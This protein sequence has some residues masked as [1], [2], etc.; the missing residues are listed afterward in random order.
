MRPLDAGADWEMA[1]SQG[2]EWLNQREHE[3]TLGVTHA[4]SLR[5]LSL[6]RQLT[7]SVPA[8]FSP[9][10]CYCHHPLLWKW[11][12]CL[13]DHPKSSESICTQNQRCCKHSDGF[14][15]RISISSFW[16][17]CSCLFGLC[18]SSSTDFFLL[19]LPSDSMVYIGKV[20]VRN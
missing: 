3:R 14:F 10:V 7:F 8:L 11:A 4:K 12:C 18:W 20:Y 17:N 16:L 6:L 2:H 15:H 5:Y 19:C 9:S 13:S 1:W